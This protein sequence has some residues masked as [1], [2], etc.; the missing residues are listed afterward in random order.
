MTTT[1]GIPLTPCGATLVVG[2]SPLAGAIAELLHEHGRPVVPADDGAPLEALSGRRASHIVHVPEVVCPTT[3]AESAAAFTSG[4]DAAVAVLEAARV[5]GLRGRI[6]V[7]SSTAVYGD[8]GGC[9]CETTAPRPSAAMAV[10]HL[11]VEQ[12]GALY[13]ATHGLDVVVLRL[14]QV[15]GR[16]LCLPAAIDEVFA[17]AAS[18]AALDLS[19]RCH[20]TFHLVHVEDARRAVVAALAADTTGRHVINVTDGETHSLCQ[21]AERI[22]ECFPASRIT[23]G[24]APVTADAAVIDIG[25]A[26]RILGYRP[27]F[28]LARGID[29]YA[30]WR[31][32]QQR[33][34]TA[35]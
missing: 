4:I 27:R 26:D 11:A 3:A 18:G 5:G 33:D 29:D 30:E 25:I 15:Y 7:L 12:L 17:A 14:G 9:I 8:R 13:R 22:R 19:P 28:G 21:V 23:T 2:R 31:S 16:G 6:V 20:E 35:A 24:A 10:G 1:P 34:G 32:A